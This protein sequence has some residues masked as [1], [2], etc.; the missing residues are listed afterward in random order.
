MSL[1]CAKSTLTTIALCVGAI[2]VAACE[3]KAVDERETAFLTNQDC[4]HKACAGETEPVRDPVKEVAIKLNGQWYVGPKDYYAGRDEAVFYW[5][6]RTPHTGNPDGSRFPEWG[7]P[8][9]EVAIEIFVSTP[10]T[11]APPS[12]H[13]RLQAIK[14][15]G[16]VLEHTILR[17]GLESWKV[18]RLDRSMEGIWFVATALKEPS[19]DAPVVACN[20]ADFRDFRCSMGMRWGDPE[21]AVSMRFHGNHATEWPEIFAEAIRVLGLLKKA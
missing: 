3:P 15:S 9:D 20:G 6:S 18:K 16:T 11:A 1:K 13:Q 4:R 21:V 17:E 19:G 5:P 7:R 8:F 12:M 2:F 10:R 14:E